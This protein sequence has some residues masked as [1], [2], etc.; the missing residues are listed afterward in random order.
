M[1]KDIVYGLACYGASI[2][3]LFIAIAVHTSV[4]F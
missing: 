2:I 1:P 4:F 3:V